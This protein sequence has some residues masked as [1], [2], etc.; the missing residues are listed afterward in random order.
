MLKSF[1][2]IQKIG[3]LSFLSFT[4]TNDTKTTNKWRKVFRKTG[5]AD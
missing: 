5:E 2:L 1:V 3:N 4:K